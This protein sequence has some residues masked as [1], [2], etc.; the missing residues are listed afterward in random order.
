MTEPAS[1][2]DCRWAWHRLPDGF[3]WCKC[4]LG[5]PE[6]EVNKC[7][8]GCPGWEPLPPSVT[9]AEAAAGKTE[10]AAYEGYVSYAHH[11]YADQQE[12]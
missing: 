5:N 11:E 2:E 4:P 12:D 10:S 3:V 6:G 8:I 9:A 1:T 7:S